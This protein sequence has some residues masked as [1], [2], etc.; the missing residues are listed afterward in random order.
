MIYLAEAILVLPVSIIM[1]WWHSRLIK[2]DRPIKH[3]WWGLVFGVIDALVLWRE[4]PDLFSVI[5]RA[6]FIA[7]CLI[8]HLIVFNISLNWLRGKPWNYVNEDTTSIIDQI[9]YRLFGSRVWLME[10]VLFLLF[11]LLQIFLKAKS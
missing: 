1:A 2:A 7:A 8:G 6:A 11:M 3:G 5:P 4:W 10:A 9:E